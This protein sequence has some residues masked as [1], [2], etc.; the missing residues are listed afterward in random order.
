MVTGG[1]DYSSLQ[2]MLHEI[3]P[4]GEVEV[5]PCQL[6]G[7][8]PAAQ[9]DVHLAGDH[10]RLWIELVGAASSA[11]LLDAVELARLPHDEAGGSVA[12]L[13][14]PYLSTSKQTLLRDRHIAFIDFAGNAWLTAHGVHIDRR[15]FSNPE[16]EK[17]EQRNLFSDKASL[18]VRTLLTADSPLGVR[19]IA[20]MVRSQDE[21]IQLT[22]GYVSKV[23]KELERRSYGAKRD[24]RVVLRHGN[25]LLKDWLVFYRERKSSVSQGYF[26]A[27][28]SAGALM[29][30]LA[31]AL[32]AHHVDYT[33]TG[34]AGASL[35]DRYAAFD[36]VDVYVKS[37][38][39]AREVLIGM[40]A[41]RADRGG[42]VNVSLPYYRVSA[43]YAT[44]ILV[45]PIRVVSDLQLYLDLYDYP[46]R[47]R[48]QAEHLY[49]RRLR[50]MVEREDRL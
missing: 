34:H 9:A 35:V 32:D 27:A 17:R 25:E 23:I 12:V 4:D 13:A 41:R 18:V 14:S 7:H 33:F 16:K 3:F 1:D 40:G 24:D 45:G 50:S 8:A 49:E 29:P 28:P 36:V 15:G 22:P 42:N 47:G 5:R 26:V 6:R 39:E 20:D 43:F 48:E 10:L 44:Q 11:R 38:E 21:H 2:S 46:V 37:L 30:G 19:Q 31:H